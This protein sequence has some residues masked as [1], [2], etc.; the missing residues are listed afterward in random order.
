MSWHSAL[1]VVPKTLFEDNTQPW[2]GD[3]C[4]AADEVPGVLIS[5]RKIRVAQPQMSDV[6]ATI[7]KESDV[8]QALGTM[9]GDSV[10]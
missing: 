3:H 4:M 2:I 7:L 5:N 8:P 10:F 9:E 1:G 6:P